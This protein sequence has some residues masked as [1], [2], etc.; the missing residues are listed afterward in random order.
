LPARVWCAARCRDRPRFLP[1]E[2]PGR[3]PFETRKT[4]NTEPDKPENP[5]ARIRNFIC[6]LPAPT[7]EA[8][9][10]YEELSDGTLVRVED[11][12]EFRVYCEDLEGFPLHVVTPGLQRALQAAYHRRI[13]EAFESSDVSEK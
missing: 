13:E 1:C 12:K 10:A 11:T 9:A 3:A 4:V 7:P 2:T 5:I 8:R 6:G